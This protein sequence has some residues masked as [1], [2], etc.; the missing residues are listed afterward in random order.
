MLK[1]YLKFNIVIE[2]QTCLSFKYITRNGII[3]L[4]HNLQYFFIINIQKCGKLLLKSVEFSIPLSFFGKYW[5]NCGLNPMSFKD[6]I[7]T[8]ITYTFRH[9]KNPIP[10]H[11]LK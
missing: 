1:F 3:M 7:I 10:G 8:T 4:Y 6:T 5:K 2:S 9:H 11:Y